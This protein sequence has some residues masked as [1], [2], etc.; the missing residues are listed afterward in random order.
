MHLGDLWV[1]DD[2]WAMYTFDGNNWVALTNNGL[3]G[4]DGGSGYVTPDQLDATV[5]T[6]TFNTSEVQNNLNVAVLA[7][8]QTHLRIT[9][10]AQLLGPL[11]L[12]DDSITDDKQAT[13]KEFV[14]NLV[15]TTTADYLPLSGGRITGTLQFRRGNKTSDQYHQLA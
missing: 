12:S 5:D 13:T 1:D 14:D 4:G 6:L 10:Q 3:V 8:D 2:N 11:L 7:L 9:P 15:T